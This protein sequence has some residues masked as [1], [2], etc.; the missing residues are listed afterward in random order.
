M[1]AAAASSPATPVTEPEGERLQKVL[2]RAGIGSRRAVEELIARGR[3]RVNGRRAELG[4]RVDISKDKVEVDGLLVPLGHGLVYYLLNKP[5]GVVTTASDDLGRQTVVELVDPQ[6][7]VWPV[8]RLDIDT[9]GAIILTNDG[10]LTHRLTHPSFEVPK[11]YV[12]EVEGRIGGAALR[13]LR[14]GVDLDD[15]PARPSQASIVEQSGKRSLVEITVREGRNRLVRRMFSAVGHPVLRLARVSI[16][17]VA[18]GRLKPGAIRK[19]G[20]EE[21]RLLYN[22]GDMTP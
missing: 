15:G 5:V 17:P 18:L 13:R 1:S 10:E 20:P 14:T 7:R 21:V 8:G 9:E 3:V 19:L 2:A 6:V 16:G 11:T 4:R 12:A 22:A